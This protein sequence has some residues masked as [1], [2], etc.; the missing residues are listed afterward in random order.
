[1]AKI[2]SSIF[3]QSWIG[4]LT[5]IVAAGLG[6]IITA[7]LARQLG[8]D[9]FGVYSVAM[10]VMNLITIFTTV[11]LPVL[12]VRQVATYLTNSNWGLL[13]GIIFYGHQWPLAVSLVLLFVTAI[14]LQFVARDLHLIFWMCAVLVP[15]LAMNQIRAAILRGLH[16]VV[17]ADV[18]ELLIR[19][20]L[21]LV[22]IIISIWLPIKWVNEFWAIG[23]QIIA[24]FGAFIIGALMLRRALPVELNGVKKIY[25]RNNW[26]PASTTFL[27]VAAVSVAESQMALLMI[28]AIAGVKEAGLY[29]AANQMVT[30]MV[31]GLMSINMALQSKLAAAIAARD[32]HQSQRLVSEAAKLTLS[33][34]V[35]AAIVLVVFAEN[36]LAIFGEDFVV[37][38]STLRVLVIGQLV[39]ALTGSCGVVLAMSGHQ[40]ILLQGAAMALFINAILCLLLIPSWGTIGAAVAA[41]V[42]LIV[43]N[44]YF[45]IQSRKLT[46]IDTTIFIMLS[47][48]I[49]F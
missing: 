1:M 45:L 33:I 31:F 48:R 35:F 8:P 11:G 15:L 3:Q 16:W 37:A 36:I 4:L 21:A 47:K 24:T 43:W 18:P 32:K 25:D 29:Q 39:N 2:K 22:L 9:K 10:A 34:A 26:V 38:S 49:R 44:V 42:G 40:R 12:L 5:K 17:M 28:G 7:L 13:K 6:F 14:A 41:S 27:G 46:G 19:P 20:F 30:P 23:I